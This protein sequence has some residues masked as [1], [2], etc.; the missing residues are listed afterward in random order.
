MHSPPPKRGINGEE[1]SGR[2]SLGLEFFPQ[3]ERGNPGG[4]LTPPL[5]GS[6]GRG[7]GGAWAEGGAEITETTVPPPETACCHLPSGTLVF[8]CCFL[9]W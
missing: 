8:L 3:R 7:R 4:A 9:H 5:L 1:S 2:K 6:S